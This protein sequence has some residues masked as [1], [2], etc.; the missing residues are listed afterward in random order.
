MA[1]L[2]KNLFRD[3]FV[4]YGQFGLVDLSIA[5]GDSSNPSFASDLLCA[6]A[7]IT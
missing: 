5:Q 4:S 3:N 6:L 7:Q 1:K 2:K